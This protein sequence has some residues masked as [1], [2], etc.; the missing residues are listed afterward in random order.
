[1]LNKN[2]KM[3]SGWKLTLLF[4]LTVLAV[5][6]VSCTE[7]ENNQPSPESDVLE[8]IDEN[9][10]ATLDGEIFYVVEEMPTF[11][12]GDAAMEFRKYIGRNVK[13]PDE[14]VKNGATGKILIKFIVNKEGKVFVPDQKTLAKA[15]GKPLDEVV[16]ISFRTLKEG[17]EEPKEEY[18]QLLKDEAIRVVSSSPNWTP[19]KQRGKN[20]NVMYTFPINFALQ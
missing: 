10:E 14:A 9:P 20:V 4:P 3:G 8:I 7:N 19:G 18:M 17:D 11:N 16:V 1:M 15:E 5:F 12:G 2:Y 6:F 13:Y